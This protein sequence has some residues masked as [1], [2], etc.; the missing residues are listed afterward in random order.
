MTRYE[1]DLN[2]ERRVILSK[3]VDNKETL[4]GQ[5]E[6][7]L[8]LS[9]LDIERAIQATKE[10]IE[11]VKS[12]EVDR[13]VRKIKGKEASEIIRNAKENT[14]SRSNRVYNLDENDR[15]NI[16]LLKKQINEIL[17]KRQSGEK[18]ENV[19][20]QIEQIISIDAQYD[21]LK[22]MLSKLENFSKARSQIIRIKNVRDRAVTKKNRNKSKLEYSIQENANKIDELRKEQQKREDVKSGIQIVLAGIMQKIEEIDNRTEELNNKDELTLEEKEYL[23]G[24]AI[25]KQEYL[26]QKRKIT[27]QYKEEEQKEDYIDKIKELE[28]KNADEEKKLETYNTGKTIEDGVINRCNLAMRMLYEGKTWDDIELAA[29]EETEKVQPKA[30]IAQ[31]QEQEEENESS[32]EIA[33]SKKTKSIIKDETKIEQE[34]EQ[35]P[36]KEPEQEKEAEEEAENETEAEP[37]NPKWY[38]FIKRFKNWNEKRKQVKLLEQGNKLEEYNE[39]EQDEEVEIV[40]EQEPVNE[41]VK[42]RDVFIS[43]LRE[44]AEKGENKYLSEKDQK[45]Y[46]N[47]QSKNKERVK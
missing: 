8:K 38:Q 25:K 11:K 19:D 16:H 32:I 43:Y 18:V 2:K 39:P 17:E 30:E 27:K 29:A 23:S 47:Q 31:N 34:N 20:N 10:E 41:P 3:K 46:Q 44:M 33:P 24:A 37:S 45:S 7:L 21:K 5:V 14:S 40:S 22:D 42:S 28:E 26:S 4:L 9:D 15:K 35:E 1:R 13:I 12:E 36:S 6:D